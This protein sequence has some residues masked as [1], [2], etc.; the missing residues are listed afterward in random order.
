MA[1]RC[2]HF[3]GGAESELQ[4]NI[5]RPCNTTQLHFWS[6]VEYPYATG[7]GNPVHVCSWAGTLSSLS[8]M[9]ALWWRATAGNSQVGP[10]AYNVAVS[11]STAS[12]YGSG[13]VNTPSAGVPSGSDWGQLLANQQAPSQDF[14]GALSGVSSANSSNATDGGRY[15][16]DFGQ[17]QNA[18]G[19]PAA[20]SRPDGLPG[21]NASLW[22]APP[23][24][25]AGSLGPIEHEACGV[26]EF[27]DPLTG[28][29][30]EHANEN[31]SGEE[32][33]QKLGEDNAEIDAATLQP[34]SPF[35]ADTLAGG[36]YV[37]NPE[38]FHTA[39]GWLGEAWGSA[40]SGGDL[41]LGGYYEIHDPAFTFDFGTLGS[42]FGFGSFDS[43]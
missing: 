41:G 23:G 5:P 42:G 11:G 30:I 35:F 36:D 22:P 16:V 6:D 2:L 26:G 28:H 3:H 37:I 8:S 29:T 27:C 7:A 43:T 18:S 9:L 39:F 13:M 33:L 38:D 12:G 14:S 10:G 1:G 24:L 15:R 34:P 20:V 31:M 17:F 19:L 40:L 4:C 21:P 25:D 32:L